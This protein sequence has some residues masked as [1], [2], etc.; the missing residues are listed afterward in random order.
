MTTAASPKCPAIDFMSGSAFATR[1]RICAASAF[2]R[3]YARGSSILVWSGPDDGSTAS[4][5]ITRE[6]G[7]VE[8]GRP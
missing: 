6:P 8:D 5:L 3:G 7:G 1:S 2:A 4:C